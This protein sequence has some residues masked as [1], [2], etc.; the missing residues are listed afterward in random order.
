MKVVHYEQVESAPVE[1]EG[2]EGCRIRRLVGPEDAAPSFSMRQFEIA[3]G[4]HTPRHSHAH[5]HE[6][7]VLEGSGLVLEDDVEHPLQPGSVVYVPP[8]QMHQFRNPGT[9][10]LKFLCLVPHPLQGTSKPCSAARG[11]D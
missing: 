11:C 2:A 4:G 6:V 9:A 1:T 3:P 7:F 10:A 5:E 8:R